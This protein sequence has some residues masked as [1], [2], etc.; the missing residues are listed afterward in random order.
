M[1]RPLWPLVG[2]LVIATFVAAADP[3]PIDK[4]LAIQ[5]A[6]AEAKAYLTA[7]QPADAVKSLEAVLTSINGD[8]DFLVM[9]RQAYGDELKQIKVSRS[10]DTARI[11]DLESKLAILTKNDPKPPA[12]EAGA[13]PT[14][15]VDVPVAVP[16]P[17]AA[18][19][20]DIVKQATELF[21]QARSQPAKF[22]EAARFFNKAFTSRVELSQEQ[23]AAWAFCRVKVAAD[24]WNK[25]AK[26]A[27]A[28]ADAVKEIEAA[29]KLVPDHAELQ[30]AGAKLIAD[31][32]GKP[33]AAPPGKPTI[34]ATSWLALESE[35]F[36]VRYQAGDD[37]AKA[38]LAKAE[39][40][41]AAIFAKWSSPPA[42]WQPKCDIVLHAGGK[43]FTTATNQPAEAMGHAF[44]KLEAKQVTDRRLDLRADGEIDETL[45]R[46]LTYVILADLFPDRD[47][48]KWAAIG[49]AVQAAATEA[50][51]CQRTLPRCYRDGELLAVGTFLDLKGPAK[52]EAV[53]A[54]YVES[55]SLVD[56]LVRKKSA[57]TFRIFLLD[58]QRYGTEKALERQYGYASPKEL[59]DEWR[60]DALVTAR[61]QKP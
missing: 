44:V 11:A 54:Y 10:P 16:T 38:L 50:E 33:T 20:I 26:D 4:A 1:L 17:K 53:T 41:R 32:G 57:K 8:A 59:D 48:P 49:M 40:A 43:E 19:E 31:I 12:V 24:G 21:N 23:F 25:S 36:R 45:A 30:A 22:A 7:S 13:V 55:V 46:E 29:L 14:P 5:R 34:T 6:M 37:A 2:T 51:R 61:G 9:L 27:A 15:K 28:K 58:A 3:T 47:P 42:A 60:R 39:E 18:D 56:H 52:P 35:N